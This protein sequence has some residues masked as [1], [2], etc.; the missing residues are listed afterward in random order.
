MGPAGLSSDDDIRSSPLQVASFAAP[1]G[2]KRGG[3]ALL[4][5]MP[6]PEPAGKQ[7]N[8][9]RKG[10]QSIFTPPLTQE[11]TAAVPAAR[12]ARTPTSRASSRRA[13]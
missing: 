12:D 3:Q 9:R 13:A 6:L 4:S 11:R 7:S 1:I 8:T 2:N 10:H 5:R